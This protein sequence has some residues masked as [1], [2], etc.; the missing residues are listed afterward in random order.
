MNLENTFNQE[1][2]NQ[3]PSEAPRLKKGMYGTEAVRTSDLFG[4]HCGQGRWENVL[5]HNGGWYN[6]SGEKLG[7]GDLDA[8]NLNQIRN[9][10]K[11]GE[12]FI[13]LS[14][15]D[16]FFN[17]VDKPDNDKPSLWS[18]VDS[19]EKAPGAE[20]VAENAMFVITPEKFYLVNPI[21]TRTEKV[22][23]KK[24][25]S[26]ELLTPDEMKNLIIPST[27]KETVS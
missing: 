3:Q 27:K 20:Y 6:Q 9:E 11:P 16:S 18:T 10:L 4:L 14:E 13:V 23:E 2:E 5:A 24:G 12:M 15:R 25:I 26:F 17:F 19:K 8:S 7:W 21:K 1:Q 22:F